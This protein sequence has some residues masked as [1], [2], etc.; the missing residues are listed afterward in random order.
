MRI[1]RSGD[2][3]RGFVRVLMTSALVLVWSIPV[4]VACRP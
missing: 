3:Q 2:P 1:P 4:V